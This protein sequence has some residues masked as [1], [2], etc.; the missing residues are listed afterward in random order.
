[1]GLVGLCLLLLAASPAP[2][3]E[4]LTID[5][6]AK[7]ETT[8]GTNLA[9]GAPADAVAAVFSIAPAVVVEE[10]MHTGA[11]KLVYA[12][13]LYTTAVAPG[14]PARL[15]VLNR[16][17]VET[18]NQLSRTTGITFSSDLWFGDQD[19]SPVVSQGVAPGQGQGPG[20]PVYPGQLPQVRLIR[21][22][23][24]D[25]RVGFYVLTSRNVRVDFDVGYTWNEGA[26]PVSR[27]ELPLQRGPFVDVK[28]EFKLEGQDSLVP[29]LRAA[30]LTYGPIF[31]AANS[32]DEK[33]SVVKDEHF[34]LGLRLSGAE[35]TLRWL[36]QQTSALSIQAGAGVGLVYQSASRDVLT[37]APAVSVAV[38]A[39]S[40]VYPIVAAAV[41]YRVS[42]QEQPLLLTA[43][44]GL[45]PI[46]NQFA[47]TV[48]ERL[49]GTVIAGWGPSPRL[50]FEISGTAAASFNP[51]DV[52]LRAEVKAVWQPS[53]HF[54]LATGARV[55]WVDYS[56]P[57]ALN[58]FSWSI[59]VS[60][61]GATGNYL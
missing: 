17:R 19:F 53:T 16:F 8:V 21:V 25:T 37:A 58:G 34:Q 55:A 60:I 5:V 36:R 7:A 24:S 54:A 33:G 6:G 38:P 20:N 50:Q 23:D 29:A 49:E 40:F 41:N 42:F 1:M 31:R 4:S 43:A 30:M 61:S 45:T 35:L 26:N 32:N 15:L 44:A 2:P 56:V 13:L 28:S 27:L 3:G 47:G 59:F 11:L 46:V 52:D 14:S 12:P 22:I 9:G 18:L 48:F 57:G 39:S 10:K 51:Q